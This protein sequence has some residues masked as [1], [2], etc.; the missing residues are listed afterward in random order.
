[1]HGR[2]GPARGRSGTPGGHNGGASTQH[3]VPMSLRFG[4]S[5]AVVLRM[6]SPINTNKPNGHLRPKERT[7]GK[8][9]LAFPP[10]S[11]L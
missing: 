2:P 3:T 8:K 10:Q 4:F 6:N 7:P 1:M 9:E 5:G 11:F